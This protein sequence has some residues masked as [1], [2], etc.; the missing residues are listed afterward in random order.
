[1]WESSECVSP[2]VKAHRLLEWLRRQGRPTIE[3]R[4]I[5]RLGPT[6]L[7]TKE[8]ADAALGTLRAHGLLVEEGSRPRIVRLVEESVS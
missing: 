1:M 5:L 6:D 7:R 2:L 4:E 3:F 8:A